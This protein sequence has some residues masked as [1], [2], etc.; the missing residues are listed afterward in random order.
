MRKLYIHVILLATFTALEKNP[1][2][3]KTVYLFIASF[4][5]L[6]GGIK[7]ADELTLSLFSSGTLT[8]PVEIAKADDD[9][10]F[11]VEMPGKIKIMAADGQVS[12]TPFLDITDR[13]YTDYG[14]RGL[15]GLAFHPNYKDN[16]YFYVY[17]IGGTGNQSVI[18]RFSVS[19]DDASIADP[20]SELK[21]ITYSQPNNA[22]DHKSGC[23]KFGPD[24][25]LYIAS[26]D[27]G[28]ATNGRNAQNLNSFLGKM[29]RIDV[30]TEPYG[31]PADNPFKDVDNAQPEIWA[32]G[33]RNPWKFSFDS[34]NGDLW[35][36]DVGGDFWDEVDYQP[37]NSAGGI[38]YGWP[39]YEADAPHLTSGCAA[40]ETMDFPVFS[41]YQ[42]EKSIKVSV[43]GG[44]VYRGENCKY[45]GQY[46]FTET[47]SGEMISIANNDGVWDTTSIGFYD[48]FI[49]AFEEG[50]DNQLYALSQKVPIYGKAATGVYK[51]NF[52][53]PTTDCDSNVGVDDV[54]T[55]NIQNATLFPNPAQQTVRVKNVAM[56]QSIVVLNALGKTVKTI[57][58][59]IDNPSIDISEL[60]KGVYFIQID[61][62]VL[63]LIKE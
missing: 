42:E 37:A 15:L 44:F 14:Q 17:Y 36:G 25:Y 8:Y 18:S 6:A 28:K 50:N 59:T 1:K 57:K 48:H 13:V 3:K 58:A 21:L 7:A 32:S 39:C 29:L 55:S 30:D 9:R 51:L 34:E 26:G 19:E 2:M 11:I 35:I 62:A 41:F 5:L 61:T 53:G 56:G 4:L 23:L 33:L 31:I 63:K 52:S 40:K 45:K 54:S 49:V 20:D 24:G 27:G 38:N 22:N 60:Q 12:S 10:F 46:I 16:G 43:I 47:Y